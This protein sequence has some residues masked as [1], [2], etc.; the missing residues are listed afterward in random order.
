MTSVN[1]FKFGTI[2]DDPYFIDRKDEIKQVRSVLSSP[3]HLILI[4]PRRYGKSS[5]IYKVVNDMN[6]PVIAIDLQLITSVDDFA[7]QLMKRI[8]R[9]YP[10]ERIRQ[11]I[12]GFRIIPT[13]SVNALT[14][15]VDVSFQPSGQSFLNL[16]DVLNLLEKLS[17][18]K[19]RCIVVLDE[20]QDIMRLD[21]ELDRKLRAVLQV[22]KNC[23]YVFLGSQESMIRDL[24]EKKS[25][26]FYHFGYLMALSR[27]PGK[28]FTVYLEEKFK[29]LTAH[30]E[31]IAK[32]IMDFTRCHPYYT[33][34]LAF[35]TWEVL[36]PDAV[37]ENPVHEGIAGILKSHDIDYERLWGTFNNTDKKLLIGMAESDL[38]PLSDA[39]IKKYDIGASSTVFSSLKRII[40]NGYITKFENR[41][42]IDDPF[43]TRW[44][45]N[46]RN[47]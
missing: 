2:V 13:L 35:S 4:S 11:Y 21:R 7:A 33:Q 16:E 29:N 1:P 41:Y 17:T 24:F 36:H 39:F 12:K 38:S 3:N 6:R 20:F 44:I 43:F 31:G 19:K 26:P 40:R 15:A 47:E 45:I 32:Q 37:V 23:N 28:E 42:E 25:S 30:A 10:G 22:Q 8:Y 46:R 14:N 5:L 9:V 27:I 18:E 34:Q